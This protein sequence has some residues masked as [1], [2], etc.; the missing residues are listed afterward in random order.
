MFERFERA[1][2]SVSIKETGLG[3]AIAKKTTEL[4]GGQTGVED[5]EDRKGSIFGITLPCA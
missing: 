3:L 5:R 2:S 1:G 4:H